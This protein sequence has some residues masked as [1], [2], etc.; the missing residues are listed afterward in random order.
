MLWL[1]VSSLS[2]RLAYSRTAV[3]SALEGRGISS[4]CWGLGAGRA[5]VSPR[6]VET[7]RGWAVQPWT[8][9]VD[10]VLVICWKRRKGLSGRV[11]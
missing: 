8:S 3:A 6:K 9:R 5:F 10:M 4:T 11:N 1:K 7:E 2:S